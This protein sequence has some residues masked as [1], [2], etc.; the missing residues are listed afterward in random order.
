MVDCSDI[1]DYQRDF[2]GSHQYYRRSPNVRSDIVS[3]MA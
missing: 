1:A 3:V 2:Q